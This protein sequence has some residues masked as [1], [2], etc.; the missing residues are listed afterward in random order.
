MCNKLYI[1]KLSNFVPQLI[2]LCVTKRKKDIN[3]L[4]GY[5]GTIEDYQASPIAIS[6]TV[7]N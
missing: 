4:S 5:C 2:Q 3:I 7:R 1:Y 6:R